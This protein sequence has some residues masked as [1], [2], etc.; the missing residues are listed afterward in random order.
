MKAN[1]KDIS[2]H[3]RYFSFN[4]L[5][6]ALYNSVFSEMG[7]PFAN[8]LS[9]I[10]AAH[11]AE[12]L[13]KARIAEEH[14][15]LIFKKYPPKKEITT[16]LGFETLFNYGRS[17][18][19]SELPYILLV[20][21]GYKMKKENEFQEF[22]RLRNGLIHFAIPNLDYSEKTL[23]FIFEVLDPMIW[24]FWDESFLQDA[25]YWSDPDMV[26]EGY[27]SDTLKNYGVS[28]HPKTKET[29]KKL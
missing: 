11:G 20:T 3:M 12:I 24:D 27:L 14:P 1:L 26:S 6:S 18:M 15:L 22:G 10:N 7:R 8:S 13:I 9:V 2:K 16:D 5:G 4:V 25:A 29:I 17:Y 28:V 23:K 19:Y 21:T